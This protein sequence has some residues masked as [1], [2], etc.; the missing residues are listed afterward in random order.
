ML[1]LRDYKYIDIAR[2]TDYL[3]SVDPGVASELTQRIKSNSGVDLSGGFDFHAFKFAGGGRKG[4][5]TEAQQTVRIY[6]QHMFNRL[7]GE[8]EK[9][10]AIITVDLHTSLEIDSLSKSSVLEITRQFRPSPL[11]QMLDTFVEVLDMMKS[12]GFEEEDLADD[13]GDMQLAEA[14][15]NLFR[16]ENRS[17]E[18]PM[19]AKADEPNDASVVFLARENFL[20]GT[21]AEFRGEMTLFGKVAELIPSGSSLDLLDLLKVLP[22]G[23]REAGAFGSEF[24]EKINDLM[25]IWPKDFGGP[26]NRD[27]VILKGPAVVVTPVAAYTI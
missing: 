16:G 9:T 19:F 1:L 24:K 3:S 22:P 2:V 15:I 14:V 10:G 26:I 20:L 17:N 25:G 12:L 7:Y 4:N 8:L 18:V 6:G 5:E 23:V 13:V 11:N 27:E 21:G